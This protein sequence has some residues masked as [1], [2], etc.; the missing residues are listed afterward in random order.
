MNVHVIHVT[1]YSAAI[2]SRQ[3]NSSSFHPRSVD[4]SDSISEC[5]IVAIPFA[6]AI[7]FG[8]HRDIPTD[9]FAIKNVT[10]KYETDSYSLK[11]KSK[12]KRSLVLDRLKR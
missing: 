10:H 7:P 2:G 1:K 5:S 6:V 9:R 8:N 11:F 3:T 4:P 12:V